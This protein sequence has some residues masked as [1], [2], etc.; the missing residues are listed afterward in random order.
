MELT[1]EHSAQPRLRHFQ[2]V[3]PFLTVGLLLRRLLG[4]EM[5]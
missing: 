3:T 1:L 5:S 4:S 2:R